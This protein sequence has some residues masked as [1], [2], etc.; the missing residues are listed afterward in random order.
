MNDLISI[1]IPTYNDSIYLK[2]C[3]DSIIKQTIKNFEI[4]IVDDGS[5][6]ETIKSY[7]TSKIN[8]IKQNK[9]ISCARNIG[10]KN[11]KGKYITF[12]DSDDEIS[13]KHLE[14]LLNSFTDNVEISIVSYSRNK[15]YLYSSMCKTIN[16]YSAYEILLN[17]NFCG[18]VWNKLFLKQIIDDNKLMF[19][20]EISVGEDFLFVCEYLKFTKNSNVNYSKSYFYRKHNNQISKKYDDRL[21]TVLDSW[22]KIINIYK[23]FCPSKVNEIKYMY[24]KKAIEL[25]NLNEKIEYK[26]LSF[27]QKII[28]VIYKCFRKQII[29]IKRGF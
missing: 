21:I 23:L 13:P 12:V 20:E 4:I 14:I 8:Y 6:E 1:I 27:K 15:K 28:I 25:N 18:Y 17:K 29:F 10:L 9:G 26:S 16:K 7:N 5:N 22:K 11:A 3:I 2:E 19:D 24:Y